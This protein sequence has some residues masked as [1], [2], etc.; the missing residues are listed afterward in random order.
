MG[1]VSCSS[2]LSKDHVIKNLKSDFEKSSFKIID[3]KKTNDGIWLV[4]EKNSER[5][6]V[7]G[8]IKKYKNEYSLKEM[9]EDMGPYYHCP[10]SL[11]KHCEPRGEIAK[12]FRERCINAEKESKKV[13]SNLKEKFVNNQRI[14]IYEKEYVIYDA[15]NFKIESVEN[16]VIYKIKKS[17]LKDIVFS[18]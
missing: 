1:S 3:E 13:K 5:H 18:S 12:N 7:M 2:W 11:F 8:L 10:T 14:S 9:S 17:Q 15:E 16:G 6:I 4:V